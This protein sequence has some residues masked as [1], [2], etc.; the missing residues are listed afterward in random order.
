MKR[1]PL[2]ELHYNIYYICTVY[3][4]LKNRTAL[5]E[6]TSEHGNSLN[7]VLKR[8]SELDYLEV[9]LR[10]TVSQSV[11]LGVEPHLGLMTRYL[12]L[13][14]SYG[15]VFVGCHLWREDGPVFCIC[16]W[17]LPVQ[18]FS[19]LSPF[20]FATIF[21]V[22]DLRL[23]YSS[24]PTTHRVTVEVFDPASIPVTS[25]LSLSLNLMLRPTVSRPVCL[26][27]KHPSGACDQIFISARNTEYIWRLRSWFCGAPSLTRGRVCLCMCPWPLP[28]QS[29]RVLVIWDLW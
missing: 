28:V 26:G 8:N 22:S 6:D 3:T 20:G 15:L 25:S 2:V 29:S 24:P 19:G 7:V 9:T 17:P 21:F 1:Q 13:Y 12:L 16:C 23:P 27:I 18:S 11:S 4:D 14:E 10:L 5:A